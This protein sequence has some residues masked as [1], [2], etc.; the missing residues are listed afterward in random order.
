M[1]TADIPL[2]ATLPNL[3]IRLSLLERH[4][5]KVRAAAADIP[6]DPQ[7]PLLSTNKAADFVLLRQSSLL[8]IKLAAYLARHTQLAA[9][10]AKTSETQFQVATADDAQ[11]LNVTAIEAVSNDRRRSLLG[12]STARQVSAAY[13][14]SNHVD[15]AMV[16]DLCKYA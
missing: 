9:P 10:N 16:A 13:I 6:W 11:N 1:G 8:R 7:T 15:S 5:E 14:G 3:D 4:P 12:A 2:Q